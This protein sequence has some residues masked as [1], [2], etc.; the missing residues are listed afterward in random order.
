M[1][2]LARG[3]FGLSAVEVVNSGLALLI[4]LMDDGVRLSGFSHRSTYDITSGGGWRR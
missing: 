3:S 1:I 2:W 4:V